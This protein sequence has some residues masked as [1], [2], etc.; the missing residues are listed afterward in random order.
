MFLQV[1]QILNILLTKDVE[2]KSHINNTK[3]KKSEQLK[4]IG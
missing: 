1:S 3:H 4:A 2:Y